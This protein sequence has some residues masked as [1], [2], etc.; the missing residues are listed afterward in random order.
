MLD[1]ANI[2]RIE[3]TRSRIRRR[4]LVGLGVSAILA[5]PF[6]WLVIWAASEGVQFH[7][8][9]IGLPLVPVLYFLT[10][11]IAGQSF[12]RLAKTWDDLTGLQRFGLGLAI[13]AMAV[14]VFAVIGTLIS[15]LVT[16]DFGRWIGSS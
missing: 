12:G 11:L 13:F 10:E 2:S 4:A 14:A 6:V 5:V 16:G 15:L 7:G 1:M 8:I 9:G 3:D